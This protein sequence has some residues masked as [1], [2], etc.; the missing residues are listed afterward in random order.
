MTA[1]QRDSAARLRGVIEQID[2][3]DALS[4]MARLAD[5]DG[6][7]PEITIETTLAVLQ[8]VDRERVSMDVFTTLDAIPVEEVWRTSGRTRHGYV[9]PSERVWEVFE[10]TIRPYRDRI[11]MYRTLSLPDAV[12]AYCQ[13]C[14]P[15]YTVSTRNLARS[16]ASGWTMPRN[17]TFRRS[18]MSGATRKPARPTSKR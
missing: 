15:G 9:D 3:D 10:E 17:R 16:I 13:G 7:L 8:D 11:A 1:E 4:V 14:W 2:G 18:S 6:E 5:R 12:M